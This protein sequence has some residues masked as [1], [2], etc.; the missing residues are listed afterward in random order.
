M[1]EV[2]CLTSPT[3]KRYI[4]LSRRLKGRLKN[5]RLI[6]KS[7]AKAWHPL[8]RAI[9][10]HGFDAF[11]V[12]V[13]ERHATE[14]AAKKAELR[15]IAAHNTITPNG[16]NVSRGGNYDGEAGGDA[17]R[18]KL[19]TDPAYRE[20]RREIGKRWAPVMHMRA[21]ADE[22]RRKIAAY[23]P[24]RLRREAIAELAEIESNLASRK[25]P[26]QDAGNNQL[27]LF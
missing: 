22:L 3:G 14:D 6:A 10:K 19:A 17:V 4:G 5:H 8:Y 13:L 20:K 12:S 27:S 23:K 15:L 16:Y 24:C 7:G 26:T 1:I 21:R 11:T 18:A 2:Y 25:S 9:V